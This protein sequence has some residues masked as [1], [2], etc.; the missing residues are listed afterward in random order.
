MAIVLTKA[1][2]AAIHRLTLEE[3][4]SRSEAITSACQIEQALQGVLRA[5]RIDDPG[6]EEPDGPLPRFSSQIKSAW[7]FGVIDVELRN[8]LDYVRKI[9]NEFAH[10]D[11]QKLFSTGRVWDLLERLSPV[12]KGQVTIKDH[13]RS[14]YTKAVF[15]I[16]LTLM[17]LMLKRLNRDESIEELR[18]MSREI[19]NSCVDLVVPS[20]TAAKE[21]DSMNRRIGD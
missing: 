2:I 6:I 1:H 21:V 20:R 5:A 11:E 10:K 19:I 9:R 13:S 7:A 12:K 3:N 4:A 8:D 14:E 16:E 18:E 17:A 15:E